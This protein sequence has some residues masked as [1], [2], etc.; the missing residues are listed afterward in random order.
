M[1]LDALLF[2]SSVL[3]YCIYLEQEGHLA[4]SNHQHREW[5]QSAFAVLTRG[6]CQTAADSESEWKATAYL[7]Y[8]HWW[9]YG[10][11]ACYVMIICCVY[12]MLCSQTVADGHCRYEDKEK[13]VHA[14]LLRGATYLC[15]WRRIDRSNETDSEVYEHDTPPQSHPMMPSGR[16]MRTSYMTIP[17]PHDRYVTMTF[18][19]FESAHFIL[20][21]SYKD[22]RNEGVR[23]S[24]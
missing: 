16:P 7:R 10:K 6:A 17:W 3:W 1:R 12:T 5:N 21:F 19:I 14:H 9:R 13:R 8:I 4:K 15:L 11:Y 24:R 2:L 23:K 20:H 22:D 18:Y